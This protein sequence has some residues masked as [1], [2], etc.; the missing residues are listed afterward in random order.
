M[1]GVP[2]TRTGAL[3][4]TD[5]KPGASTT[6]LHVPVLRPIMAQRP[7]SSVVDVISEG[8]ASR[9]IARTIAPLMGRPLVSFTVPVARADW[10][11]TGD[12]RR[13]VRRPQTTS[14]KPDITESSQTGSSLSAAGCPPAIL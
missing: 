6:N 1:G 9:L 3:A 5:V 2:A 13:M 10:A 4:S 8:D 11:N 14:R 12:E 7:L